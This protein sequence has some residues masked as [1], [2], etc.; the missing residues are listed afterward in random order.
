MK[1]YYIYIIY[2]TIWY[3]LDWLWRRIFTGSHGQIPWGPGITS[4]CAS[5]WSIV[6]REKEGSGWINMIII[7]LDDGKIYRKALYL[8]VKTIISCRFSLKSIQ[9]DKHPTYKSVTRTVS[10][11][12]PDI[13]CQMDPNPNGQSA[14]LAM[15]CNR[16]WPIVLEAATSSSWFAIESAKAGLSEQVCVCVWASL[17]KSLAAAKT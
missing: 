11:L 7:E 9:W 1:D 5:V 15:G 14:S 17:P 13:G 16:Q 6:H 12:K 2:D 8:M 3:Y 10:P 4:Q